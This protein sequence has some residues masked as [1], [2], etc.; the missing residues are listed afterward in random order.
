MKKKILTI[1]AYERDN[2]GDLLFYIITKKYLHGHMVVPGAVSSANMLDSIGEVVLPYPA[3]MESSDWDVIWVV[4]GE[5]GQASTNAGIRM[6]ITKKE[7]ET[8]SGLSKKNQLAL[9]ESYSYDTK[10]TTI[11]YLPSSDSVGPS[12]QV[13]VNSV[14]ISGLAFMPDWIR[15]PANKSLAKSLYVSVRDPES[16]KYCRDLNID[17]DLTPDIVHTISRHYN[18]LPKPAILTDDYMVF[19]MSEELAKTMDI[20]NL[21][22]NLDAIAQKYKCSIVFFAAGTANYHDNTDVYR[23]LITKLSCKTELFL[24]RNPIE[25]AGCISNSR[26]WI[27]TSLHGRIIAASYGVRRVSFVNNKVSTYAKQWDETQPYNVEIKNLD[28]AVRN[29]SLS[30]DKDLSRIADKL[31]QLAD[32]RAK[33]IVSK[34]IAI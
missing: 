25:L 16:S 30:S 18:V 2:F 24:D 8:Y 10:K 17:A 1:G 33:S 34:V 15:K 4:G 11:G 9:D 12:T 3:L 19:Q 32:A 27:G 26:M 29:A 23:N 7:E 20:S 13:I 14:G 6:S 28:S 22:K 5:I 21:V 31:S